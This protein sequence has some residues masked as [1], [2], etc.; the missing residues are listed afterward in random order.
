MGAVRSEQSHSVQAT[1]E[2]GSD[3]GVNS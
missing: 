3:T 1:G 2:I